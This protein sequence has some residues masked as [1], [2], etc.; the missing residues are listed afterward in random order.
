MYEHIII[1]LLEKASV[2]EMY[3]GDPVPALLNL[4]NAKVSF[5]NK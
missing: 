4:L 3:G 1:Q 2:T 5:P